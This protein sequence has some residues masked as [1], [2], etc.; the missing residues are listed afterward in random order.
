MGKIGGGG[1][2]YLHATLIAW[3][4]HKELFFINTSARLV[5]SYTFSL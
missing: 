2:L 1:G 4:F 3:G 5:V